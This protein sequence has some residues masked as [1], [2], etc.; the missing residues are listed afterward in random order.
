M[1]YDLS[2]ITDSYFSNFEDKDVI[3][4]GWCY[5]WAWLGRR[6]YPEAELYTF[7]GEDC[8]HAFLK[9]GDLWFDSSQPRGV[10]H[11]S[12]LKFFEE[13]IFADEKTWKQFQHEFKKYWG[14]GVHFIDQGLKPWP[15]KVQKPPNSKMLK[16]GT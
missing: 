4:E 11:P 2:W 13:F 15:R 1:E 7:E 6:A 12:S 5:V 3:N 8:S 14:G 16:T 10:Y 9:I